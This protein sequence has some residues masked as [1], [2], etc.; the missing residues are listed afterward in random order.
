MAQGLSLKEV[1]QVSHLLIKQESVIICM[2][3]FLFLGASLKSEVC[4]KY[5]LTIWSLRIRMI[6][7]Q[8]S[9]ELENILVK[10]VFCKV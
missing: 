10:V 7:K 2:L 3:Y 9:C 6:S 8:N 4:H 5:S 1:G